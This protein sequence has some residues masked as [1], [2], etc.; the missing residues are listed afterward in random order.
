MSIL[1]DRSKLKEVSKNLFLAEK[2]DFGNG[3]IGCIVT[4]RGGRNT[5]ILDIRLDK[6]EGIS[7]GTVACVFKNGDTAADTGAT[8]ISKVEGIHDVY[9][10]LDGDTSLESIEFTENN[11]YDNIKY[12][13]VPENHFIDLRND[14]W[15]AVDAVG[16]SVKSC[17]DVGRKKDKKVGIFYWTWRDANINS[18][19]QSVSKVIA[20]F[21]AAEYN[22]THPAWEKDV[23]C[24]W[25]EPLYGFYRNADPY[26]IRKHAVFLANAGIDMIMLDCTNGALLWKDS[27]E[28]VLK[29]FREAREDGINAPKVAFMLNF[30]PQENSLKMLRG[31]YQDLYKPGLYSD[32]WFMW[33]GKP[34]IMGYPECLP[35]EGTGEHDTKLLNEIRE[36]FTFRPGQPL[37]KGGPQRSDHWGWLEM[38]PQNKYCEQPDGSCEMVTVGVGQNAN[39]E[40]ICTYFNSKDSFGRSYTGKDGH[41]KLDKDSYVYGYNVQEQWDRAIDLDPEFVFITGWNEWMMGRYKEPWIKDPDSPQLAFVDQFDREHSRDIEFDRNGMKDTYYL[42]M[43]SNI[44]RFKGS[45]KR[46]VASAPV[47][48]DINGNVSQWNDVFPKFRSYKGTAVNRDF[49]GLGRYYY[50]NTTGRNDIVLAKVAHDTENLYFYVETTAA[51]TPSTDPNWMRLFINS[52][53]DIKTGW[54]GYDYIINRLNPSDGKMLVEKHLRDFDW[55][56]VGFATYTV[57]GNKMQVKVPKTLLGING[58]L[59]FEFKWS[60]N[61]QNIDIMDFYENGDTAPLGRLNYRYI[62]K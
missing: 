1:I 15:E 7:P 30:G 14:T 54:E 10:K 16:R 6:V 25:E 12:T 23:V 32:L 4:F 36:F 42:Q 55:T 11:P 49:P 35:T 5:A 43:I 53:R 58:K 2:I 24:H 22:M 47:S 21:P 3:K 60:D 28:A 27:Y 56:N 18:N 44:R 46:E 39:P 17:E 62:E 8:D 51:L 52:D 59:D 41:K 50:V 13:P 57:S 31:L 33:K 20:E 45:L 61:M 19:P 26:I 34:M 29:G 37:Y 38:Y 48:V 9:F 40:S